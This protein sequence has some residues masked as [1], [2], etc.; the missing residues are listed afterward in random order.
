VG[1]EGKA[2]CSADKREMKEEEEVSWYIALE[3]V[4]Y[5]MKAKQK[6]LQY[7][8]LIVQSINPLCSN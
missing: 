7:L 6:K 1:G 4:L 8:S 5:M 3:Q 2:F